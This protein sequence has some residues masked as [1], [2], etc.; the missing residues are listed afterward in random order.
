MFIAQMKKGFQMKLSRKKLRVAMAQKD[1]IES[2][3]RDYAGISPAQIYR[4]MNEKSG[5]SLETAYKIAK[6]LDVAIE[7]LLLLPD[8]DEE[9]E[10]HRAA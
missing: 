7:D 6:C 5:C 9:E 8:D 1:M 4:I 2:E 10:E 3:V